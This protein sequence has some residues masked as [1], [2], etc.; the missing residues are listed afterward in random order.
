MANANIIIDDACV[1]PA[2]V[3]RDFFSCSSFTPTASPTNPE[4]RSLSSWPP[5]KK[6]TITKLSDRFEEVELEPLQAGGGKKERMKL[7]PDKHTHRTAWNAYFE[8]EVAED[9]AIFCRNLSKPKVP[10]KESDEPFLGFKGCD[11]KTV[12]QDIAFT[13]S[14]LIHAERTLAALALE[15]LDD[16]NFESHWTALDRKQ[17]E[18]LV[19]EGLYRGACAAPDERSRL[20]CPEMTVSGLAGDGED[21][22]IHLLR[23]L[24]EYYT[25]GRHLEESIFLFTHPYRDL[26]NTPIK[27]TDYDGAVNYLVVVF[28]TCYIVETLRGTLEAFYH[29]MPRVTRRNNLIG[30]TPSSAAIV[31]EDTPSIGAVRKYFGIPVIRER[32]EYGCYTC[33]CI[34]AR[35]ELKRCGKCLIVRYC[36][37][38]CQKKDWNDHKKFCGVT[39]FDPALL[40]PPPPPR[41]QFI[42]CPP[43]VKGYFEIAPNRTRSVR[44]LDPPGGQLM[45]FV[46]RRRA[47]ASGDPSGVHMMLAILHYM[48]LGGMLN[49]T[50]QQI[51]SQFEK[52]YGVE[53]RS[54]GV[55]GAGLSP[56]TQQEREEEHEFH[57]Q[58]LA[59]A[60]YSE[61]DAV[62]EVFSP[63]T[64]AE[65]EEELAYQS[66]PLPQWMLQAFS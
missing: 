1:S 16:G 23:R 64:R 44:I 48:S 33:K 35:D 26:F 49:L 17:K 39:H 31:P 14:E 52:E 57:R 58:R 53:I 13:I 18:E 41:P 36:S 2:G 50:P 55:V 66:G 7:Q 45:F 24:V 63:P 38:E 60:T 43:V 4:R 3:H 34:K 54:G 6:K 22:L 32:V 15:K 59:A 21:N 30:R 12:N 29:M 11:I 40:T 20:E 28:R 61:P 8:R 51:A 25:T 19:L 42:G 27:R 9:Y 5:R 46:A 56:S 47:M 65:I 62:R 37:S 10:K